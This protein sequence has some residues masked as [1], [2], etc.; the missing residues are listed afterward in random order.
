MSDLKA[1]FGVKKTEVKEPEEKH[2]FLSDE[3]I[4]PITTLPKEKKV[5]KE[6][7]DK[8]LVK[9]AELKGKVL[10][11]LAKNPKKHYRGLKKVSKV[12]GGSLKKGGGWGPAW[13]Y[14]LEILAEVL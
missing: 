7:Y 14:L 2:D 3:I 5:P 8:I 4:I 1:R 6:K 12:W 10:V 11:A 9:L 13:T